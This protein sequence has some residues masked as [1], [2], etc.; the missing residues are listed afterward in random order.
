MPEVSETKPPISR[1]ETSVSMTPTQLRD[2][3]AALVAELRKPTEEQQEEIQKK[4]DILE[5]AKR[6]KIELVRI[7]M[8]SKRSREENCS[9]KKQNGDTCIMGQKHSDGK[10]HPIC[11]RCQKEFPPYA[12]RPEMDNGVV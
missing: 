2:F 4:K 5:R 11:V 6:D 3:A 8:E 7:E 10:V 1:P 12:L 9:H